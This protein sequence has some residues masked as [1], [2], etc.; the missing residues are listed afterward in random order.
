MMRITELYEGNCVLECKRMNPVEVP[1]ELW[2]RL[3]AKRVQAN[4][5]DEEIKR[6]VRKVG[7]NGVFIS[8]TPSYGMTCCILCGRV[9]ESRGASDHVH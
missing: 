8:I 3:L 9:T 2:H 6:L 1:R 5:V 4:G 7:P